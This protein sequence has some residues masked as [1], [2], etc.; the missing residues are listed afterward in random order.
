[1]AGILQHLKNSS[2][3]HVHG[4]LCSVQSA[5]PIPHSPHRLEHYWIVLDGFVGHV[6]HGL[7]QTFILTH[8]L[9]FPDNLQEV[10]GKNLIFFVSAEVGW[11]H[12]FG[13]V[14]PEGGCGN[15]LSDVWPDQP[16]PRSKS[17]PDKKYSFWA[18]VA[19]LLNTATHWF[20][21]KSQISPR[22]LMLYVTNF[23]FI[24]D[25]I[26]NFGWVGDPTGGQ[27]FMKN[28]FT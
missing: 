18:F 10:V 2:R 17:C 26:L 19:L 6:I 28:I 4:F 5:P 13:S 25:L 12:V 15:K 7:H 20:V 21:G 9:L 16:H 23:Q 14:S 1:M 3:A 24:C 27:S 8:M 11:Y 22:L